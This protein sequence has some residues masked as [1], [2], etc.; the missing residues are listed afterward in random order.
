VWLDDYKKYLYRTDPER[1][2]KADAGDLTREKLIRKN[3][4]CKPFRYFLENVMPD[5]LERYPLEDRGVFASGTIQSEMDPQFCV[6]AFLGVNGFEIKLQNCDSNL[7]SQNFK[8]SWYRQ[9]KP[10]S[11]NDK[12]LKHNRLKIRRCTY[13]SVQQWF[14]NLVSI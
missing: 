3:L 11:L 8:L 13:D 6:E 9:I 1:Y 14:Y 10:D 2:A 4:K 7:I 5:M 12:C